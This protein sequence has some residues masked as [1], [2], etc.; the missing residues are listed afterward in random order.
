MGSNSNIWDPVV[1]GAD[2]HLPRLH[3]PPVSFGESPPNDPISAA[4]MAGLCI[5]APIIPRRDRLP[6]SDIHND[7]D[8]LL[9]ITS[10]RAKAQPTRTAS[11]DSWTTLSV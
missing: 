5:R 10:E 3:S 4:N 6:P 9:D 7:C 8:D 11:A 2:W 1:L